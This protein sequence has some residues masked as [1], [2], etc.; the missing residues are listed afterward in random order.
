MISVNTDACVGAGQCVLAAESLFDQ[1][2]DG[3]V[4]LLD[5]QPD[6]GHAVAARRAAA[7]CPARAISIVD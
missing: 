4:I 6:A 3:I 2:D 1:D 5:A 7:L